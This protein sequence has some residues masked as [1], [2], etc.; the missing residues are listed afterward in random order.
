VRPLALALVMLLLVPV[1]AASV[2]QDGRVRVLW[3]S[4]P[5]G[6]RAR[7]RWDARLSLLQGPGGFDPGSARP[8]IV[9]TEV[10]SGAELRTPM[11]VDVAPNTFKATVEFPRAGLYEVAAAGFDSRDP[12][13][14][15]D[16]GARVRVGSAPSPA[17]RGAGGRWWSWAL[18][19]AAVVA[20]G[21]CIQRAGARADRR[22]R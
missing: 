9:I 10:A 7:G 20:V 22:R 16:L 14:I 3:N 6:V 21:W 19:V 13:R 17:A 15:T 4:T 12:R 5:A 1:A 11:V 8:V 18:F 2:T